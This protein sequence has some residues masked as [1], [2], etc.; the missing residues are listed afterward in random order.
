MVREDGVDVVR[1]S[2]RPVET[3]LRR[4]SSLREG[5]RVLMLRGLLVRAGGSTETVEAREAL[6]PPELVRGTRATGVSRPA[7]SA[8]LFVSVR[9]VPLRTPVVR[10]KASSARSGLERV[11]RV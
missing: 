7:R 5:V 1:G 6:V 2:V 11:A 3:T 4:L 8:S 10:A 9:V